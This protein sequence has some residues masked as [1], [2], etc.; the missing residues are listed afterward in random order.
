MTFLKETLACLVDFDEV[1]VVDCG[2]TDKTPKIAQS[3]PNVKFFHHDWKD[4]ARQKQWALDQCTHE[5][6]DNVDADE[7]V[8]PELAV[9][10]LHSILLNPD[11]DADC[12]SAHISGGGSHVGVTSTQPFTRKALNGEVIHCNRKELY[13][14]VKIWKR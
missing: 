7:H 10:I 8:T 11:S 4:F 12:G 5:W 1:V 13:N 9:A 6:V 14:G 3:F 2:S